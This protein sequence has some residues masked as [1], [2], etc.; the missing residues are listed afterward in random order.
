V[1]IDKVKFGLNA[2]ARQPTVVRS[3]SINMADL[4][5]NLSMMI[6]ETGPEINNGT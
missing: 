3:P 1:K 5:L 4:Q 2:V 6:L